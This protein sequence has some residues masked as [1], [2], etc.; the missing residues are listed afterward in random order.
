M[1]LL[2]RLFRKI[3]AAVALFSFEIILVFGIFFGSL[4]LFVLVWRKFIHLDEDQLDY[5]VF[6]W[7]QQYVTGSGTVFFNIITF[8]A[9]KYFL[10]PASSLLTVYFLF[11][12][13][14]KWYSLKVPVV[15]LG[16]I[17]INVLMKELFRRPRPLDPLLAEASGLS[18][19]SGHAML[20]VSFYGLLIY[21]VWRNI[22]NQFLRLGL[23]ISLIVLIFLIGFSRIYL[24]VHYASD[25]LA[26]FAV[27]GMW[28]IISITL[29]RQ[30]EK[31][32]G[33]EIDPI[34][35]KD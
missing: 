35:K 33:R 26:G 8:F 11:I 21:L 4:L 3:F 6:H 18:F 20:A 2:S 16:G 13:R 24:R 30:I 5:E 17:S 23:T 27:G 25:V 1:Q 28:V 7:L 15:A 14:H 12:R 31:Y 29:L 32:S 9:S 19:P 34:V 10:I 22:K